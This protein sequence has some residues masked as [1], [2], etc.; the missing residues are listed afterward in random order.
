MKTLFGGIYNGK[1]VLVTGHTGFKGSWLSYWLHELGANVIGYSLNIPTNPSHIELLDMNIVSIEGDIRDQQKLNSVLESYRPDIVF[2]L[3]AQ[4]LVRYSY[5]NPVETY[6]VNVIGT[7]KVFEACR[8]SESVRAIVN[9]TSDKAYENKEWVW[10]YREIDPMGGYDPYSASKGC[11]ELVT[12]SYRRSY[13]NIEKYGKDHHVL[14]ASCRAGNVIGGGDWGKDRLI[15]DIMMAA[16]SG[17]KVSLRN[18]N[19]I[20]PWQHVLEPLSGYLHLGWKLLEGEKAFAGGWNFGPSDDAVRVQEVV[21][22]ARFHW[23]KIEYGIDREGHPHEA[24]MLK[25]DCSKAHTQLHWRDVWDLQTTIEKVTK[26]YEIY[27]EKAYV[28]TYHDLCAYIEAAKIK[29]LAWTVNV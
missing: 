28:N 18:P 10:G 15:P 5:I 6:E 25:L 14:L 27:Y 7:L 29:K 12:T 24:K 22:S 3:A 20:R 11:A 17:E 19:A 26:W 1:T 4:P 23:S 9:I 8:Q 16:S 21:E 2:H 13:F